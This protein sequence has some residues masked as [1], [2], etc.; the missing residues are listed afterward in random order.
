MN[1]DGLITGKA[2]VDIIGEDKVELL[3]S[4]LKN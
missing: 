3:E 1:V 4:M 2:T